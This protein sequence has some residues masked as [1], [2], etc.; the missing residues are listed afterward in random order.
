MTDG[1]HDVNV[2]YD[3]ANIFSR[4]PYG[5]LV[6]HD[7]YNAPSD[8]HRPPPPPSR[9]F[10]SR[11]LSIRASFS[12]QVTAELQMDGTPVT[13]ENQGTAAA[14]D[15]TVKEGQHT[16]LLRATDAAGNVTEKSWQAF[17]DFTPPKIDTSTWPPATWKKSS[18]QTLNFDVS[19]NFMNTVVVSAALDGAPLTPSQTA[20]SGNAKSFSLT[21]GNLAEGTHTVEVNAVDAGGNASNAKSTFLVN[22]SEQFGTKPM[23][24]GA[25]GADVKT[26]QQILKN[27]GFYSGTISG[28]LDDATAQAVTAYKQ[29]YSLTSQTLVDPTMFPMLLGH[30]VVS[31]SKC[32]LTLYQ[33]G[34]LV[35][36]Y[37]VAVGMPAWPTPSGN[38][39]IISK[40]VNPTWVPPNS[41]WA[42]GAVPIPPGPRDPIAARWMGLTAPGVG[43]HGTNRA[44]D[45]WFTRLPRLHAHARP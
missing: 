29:K 27:K 36:T 11:T 3:S 12:E 17:A 2:V 45:R 14:A 34:K 26:L 30:I 37:S 43:I 41:P 19:D 20:T 1:R 21:T 6:L 13:L 42:A 44:L 22:T 18:S 10:P 32:T 39:S 38:F 15:L 33:D 16:F 5:R 4:K 24:P 35:K 31:K 40:V 28:T 23:G 9:E 7:G 8:Q 25:V